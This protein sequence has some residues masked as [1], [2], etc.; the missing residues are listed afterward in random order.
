MIKVKEFNQI[1]QQIK[2]ATG[3]EGYVI[4]STEEQGT[5]KLHDKDGVRLV[6]VYPSYGFDGIED[7]YKSTHEMLFFMVVRQIE[8]SDNDQELDQY[9]DTQEAI[10]KLKQF[11]FGEDGHSGNYC[12]L[13]PNLQ[14]NSVTI[15]PEYNIFGGYI[16]WS[17]KLVC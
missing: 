11:L 9:A 10:I 7:N 2:E 5:K 4:S 12:K 17:M 15:D 8:G 1:C 13:F 16:G 6:A 3:I 14:I